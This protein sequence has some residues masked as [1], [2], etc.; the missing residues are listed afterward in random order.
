MLFGVLFDQ[1]SQERPG[2]LGIMCFHERII[3]DQGS[4]V[5]LLRLAQPMVQHVASVGQPEF[6]FQLSVHV[7]IFLAQF[8]RGS[9]GLRRAIGSDWRTLVGLGNK[10]P[11]APRS[12]QLR[13]V[14][15]VDGQRQNPQRRDLNPEP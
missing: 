10:I 13:K 6:Y 1:N 8:F 12:C 11:I 2:G 7:N 9:W 4:D 15:S 14:L 5:T 3:T